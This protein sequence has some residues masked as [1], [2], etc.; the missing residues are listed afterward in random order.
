MSSV[1]ITGSQAHVVVGFEESLMID[2]SLSGSGFDPSS[3]EDVAG[4]FER[5]GE[6]QGLVLLPSAAGDRLY[7]I[8][9]FPVRKLE[10]AFL[11]KYILLIW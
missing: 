4:L 3:R 1:C 10:L 8:Y 7:D 9:Q 2:L 6:R 11:T 5:D